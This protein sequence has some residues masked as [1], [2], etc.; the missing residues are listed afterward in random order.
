MNK[1]YKLFLLLIL[2]ISLSTYSPNNFSNTTKSKKNIFEIKNI[3]I[4]G[5]KLIPENEIIEKL[6]TLRK[7]NIFFIKK[8][9]IEKPLKNIDFLDKIYVK[10]KYPNTII[11][12][13]LETKPMG[14]LYKNNDKYLIDSSSNLILAKVK[15]N[16]FQVPSIFGKNSE[17]YYVNF[18]NKLKKN[19]FP[20]KRIKSYYYFQVGRWDLQ[21]LNDKVIKFPYINVDDAI[22]KSIELLKRKD[23]QNYN[24]IDLRVEGKIIVE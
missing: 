1:F 14:Y 21:L 12:R 22:K 23:F 19:S 6:N 15:N 20:N 9:D 7:K 10:K 4:T 5:N 24:I 16:L 11:V 13:I 18:S 3:E 2:L 8:E 17:K